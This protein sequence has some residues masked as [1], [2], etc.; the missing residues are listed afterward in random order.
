MDYGGKERSTKT[1]EDI[2]TVIREGNSS[3]LFGE[4]G[5]GA[6]LAIM[7]LTDGTADRTSAD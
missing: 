5:M 4:I 7:A 3:N 1:R 2:M 6:L